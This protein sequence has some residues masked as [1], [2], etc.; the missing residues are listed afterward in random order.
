MRAEV[1]AWF[2]E[3][4][5]FIITDPTHASSIHPVLVSFII[6]DIIDIRAKELLPEIKTIVTKGLAEEDICGDF[7]EIEMEM[8]KPQHPQEVSLNYKETL[9][10]LRGEK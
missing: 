5:Q 2:H 8:K 9:K 10:F 7:Q 1:I 6:E 4:L 3:L